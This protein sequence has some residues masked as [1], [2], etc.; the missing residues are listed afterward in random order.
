MSIFLRA[1]PPAA[2]AAAT[3]AEHEPRRVEPRHDEPAGAHGRVADHAAVEGGGAA[4]GGEEGEGAGEG[5]G[6]AEGDVARDE[7][8]IEED[9]ECPQVADGGEQA[10]EGEGVVGQ[11]VEGVGH[12]AVGDGERVPQEG[13][14]RGERA[15]RRHRSQNL[16]KT[17]VSILNI[18][19]TFDPLLWQALIQVLVGFHPHFRHS[20]C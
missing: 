16:R 1:T 15:E 14:L 10:E 5:D 17:L 7:V 9:P 12:A 8:E 13:K 4:E 3:A 6:E 11:A 18:R 20:D 2:A 19:A